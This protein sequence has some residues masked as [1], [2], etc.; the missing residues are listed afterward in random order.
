MTTTLTSIRTIVRR[1]LHDEDSNNYRWTDNEIDRHIAHA[2]RDLSQAIP[3]EK[4]STLS[5]V[6]G[7]R[8]ISVSTLIDRVGIVA[9]EW[10]VDKYPPLY[11]RF[12]LWLDTLTLLVDSAP[13]A[14]EN[15]YVFWHAQHV[16]G[17][18]STLQTWAEDILVV[19]AEGYAALEWASY[20]TNRVNVGGPN[21]VDFY[22]VFGK[23]RLDD[24]RAELRRLG[25]QGQLRARRLY[26]PA[27][28]GDS[29]ST[30]WGP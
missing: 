26:S 10:P 7:S 30:D 20:A 25:R 22:K 17:A 23:F 11:C 29:Q 16:L 27:S 28:P 15:A 6:A 9:V 12:S 18:S 13:S 1:D 21:T 19:G 3:Q 24:F 2:L 8:D 4:K 5:T 14:I